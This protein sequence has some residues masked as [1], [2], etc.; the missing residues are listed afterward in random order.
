MEEKKC[1]LIIFSGLNFFFVSIQIKLP[2]G[3]QII[4]SHFPAI[5]WH[6]ETLDLQ[7]GTQRSDHETVNSITE[8]TPYAWIL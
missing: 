3:W 8:Y 4:E 7:A 5:L 1:T 6:I 2:D